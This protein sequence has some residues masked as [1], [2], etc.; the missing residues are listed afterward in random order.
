MMRM[1]AGTLV[2]VGLGRLS[3]DDVTTL[4]DMRGRKGGRA[5]RGLEVTRAPSHG[6]CLHH[7]FYEPEETNNGWMANVDG[8]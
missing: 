8:R 1:I 6:L 5:A 2:D 4:L 7:C 3:P